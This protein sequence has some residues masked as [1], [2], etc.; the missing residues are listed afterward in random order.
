MRRSSLINSTFR[1]ISEDSTNLYPRPYR[2]LRPMLPCGTPTRS[3][4]SRPRPLCTKDRG[5]PLPRSSPPRTTTSRPTT[6]L[7]AA[8]TQRSHARG[9]SPASPRRLSLGTWDL[10]AGAPGPAPMTPFPP[11]FHSRLYSES[12]RRTAGSRARQRRGAASWAAAAVAAHTPRPAAPALPPPR[13][14]P[15]RSSPLRC[16]RPCKLK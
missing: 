6:P 1:R 10:R 5:N 16:I 4:G 9:P 14:P 15:P 7:P 12:S 11:A 8:G 3:R 13:G 2:T